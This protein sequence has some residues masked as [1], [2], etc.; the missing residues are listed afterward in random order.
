MGILETRT[1]DFKHLI[2]LSFNEGIFPK[3]SPPNTFIPHHLRY[4]FGL[5]TSEHQDA[6]FAYHF[7]RIIQRAESVTMIYDASS[8]GLKTG[9]VSRYLPQLKYIYQQEISSRTQNYTVELTAG[10]AITIKKSREVML[11]LSELLEGGSRAISASAL[12]DYIDCKLKFYF[13]QIER[14]K[15]QDELQENIN[16]SIFGTIFHHVAEHLYAP[17]ENCVI[18]KSLLY[19]LSKNEHLIDQKIKDAFQT[20]FFKVTDRDIE[21]KGRY[22][23]IA[24]LIKKYIIQLL[25]IDMKYTPFTYRKGEQKLDY[26]LPIDEKRAVKFTGFIDRVD[27]YNGQTRIIDYKTG[28]DKTLSFKKMED[29]FEAC[30]KRQ[31][32]IFQ[33]FIYALLSHYQFNYH[34]AAPQL[35]YIRQMFAGFDPSIKYN[36]KPLNGFEEHRSEFETRLKRLLLEIFNTD[37]DFTQTEDSK[38]CQYCDFKSIC[39]R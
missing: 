34:N 35:Y 28:R 8:S 11:K 1:L 5:P 9:E 19:Q 21:L 15:E 23:V 17:Y 6:I 13:R 30:D 12:N 4:G 38:K 20:E 36:N 22:L 3:T 24:T 39:M 16:E 27:E 33:T 32:A 18:E 26:A 7:Y 2:F 25:K 14:L 29:L 37:I 31:S 10:K